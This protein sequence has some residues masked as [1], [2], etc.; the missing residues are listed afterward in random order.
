MI[1]DILQRAVQL[2]VTNNGVVTGG[3]SQYSPE[4]PVEDMDIESEQYRLRILAEEYRDH[5][6]KVAK[7]PGANKAAFAVILRAIPPGSML[8]NKLSLSLEWR[9]LLKNP[10]REPFKAIEIITKVAI[11]NRDGTTAASARTRYENRDK[12]RTRFDKL[13]FTLAKPWR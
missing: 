7:I 12:A 2:P 1:D 11:T 10:A 8:H 4:L 3:P 6:I 13:T 5:K 9:T